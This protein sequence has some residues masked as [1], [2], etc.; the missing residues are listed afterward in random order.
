MEKYLCKKLRINGD[1]VAAMQRFA[2]FYGSPE[3]TAAPGKISHRFFHI[4]FAEQ[5]GLRSNCHRS[6]SMCNT[7]NQQ[8]PD[9]HTP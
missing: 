1:N 8:V 4:K 2:E 7:P 6:M 3:P 9:L 5:L